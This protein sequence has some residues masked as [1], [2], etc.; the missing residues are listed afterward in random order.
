MTQKLT[1][2]LK[3]QKKST[4]RKQLQIV[5]TLGIPLGGQRLTEVPGRKSFVY[6]KLRDNQNEV[7][8]AFN[9]KVAASY[10]LPV[11]VERRS[12]RYIVL[13]VDTVRY[14]NNWNSFAPFLPIHGNTHSFD[15][16]NGGGGDVVWVH[17]RQIMP[18]LIIPSG[19]LGAP[20][21]LMSSYT[22]QNPD[23]TWKY[24][25]NTGTPNLTPYKPH[26]TGTTLVLVYLDVPTGN[27][28]FIFATGTYISP[29]ITGTAQL[30]PFFPTLT[31][32]SNRIPLSV[33]RL[34][35]GTS[36]IGWD[37]IYDVRQ[38]IHP[39]V[40]GTGGGA[41][42]IAISVDDTP[43]G[44]F[45][46]INFGAGHSTDYFS[47]PVINIYATGTGLVN[48]TGTS[49]G[50]RD[51]IVGTNGIGRLEAL[52]W[53]FWNYDVFSNNGYLKFG[54]NITGQETNA[55]VV[56]YN[57]F[58]EGFFDWVGAGTS[59]GNRWVRIF[60]NLKVNSHFQT[61]GFQ[62]LGLLSHFVYLNAT[63][64]FVAPSNAP[65]KTYI[66]GSDRF[67]ILDS[68]SGYA[69]KTIDAENFLVGGTYTPT[70]TNTANIDASTVNGTWS[71][72][73]IGKVV[74]V[75]GT[76]TIDATAGGGATTI[77]GISIPIAS[78]FIVGGDASGGGSA[79][80]TNTAGNVAA[81]ATNN[82]V[83]LTFQSTS[84]ANQGWK[85][86]FMYQIN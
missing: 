13:D 2:A 19:S 47:G 63:G 33:V 59:V 24:T 78:D 38:W 9:N 7:I 20:N 65:G 1:E 27:T 49:M 4:P 86:W 34:V 36:S 83:T 44:S 64:T 84:T 30:A 82:R 37:N 60:D 61:S 21:V 23:G 11:I 12:G 16:D 72:I 58:T 28:G 85:I 15:P 54:Y 14:Q 39:T 55:G 74:M 76:G 68:E 56:G 5:G 10:G 67:L 45:G 66:T 3:N 18:S 73:R 51:R 52:P 22:L 70:L 77:L 29:T 81:D 40:T 50:N 17:S 35:S 25:G 75:V 80:A 46:E 79:Q 57:V 62:N 53:L 32:P 26:S 48:L 42:T 6:V 43:M 31:S 41:G 71:Y 8:Q 69:S